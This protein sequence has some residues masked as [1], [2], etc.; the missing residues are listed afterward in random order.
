MITGLEHL[1]DVL[2]K[3]EMSQDEDWETCSCRCQRVDAT[4]MQSGNLGDRQ[5][6]LLALFDLDGSLSNSVHDASIPRTLNTKTGRTT[7]LLADEVENRGIS[8]QSSTEL[9]RGQ[10]GS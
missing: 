4:A 1:L 6:I 8:L 10:A 7:V 9:G 2:A 3:T 5:L